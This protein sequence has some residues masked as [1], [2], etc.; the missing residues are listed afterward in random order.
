M[1]GKLTARQ[2]LEGTTE[3]L[4]HREAAF[5]ELMMLHLANVNPAFG[6]FRELFD[7]RGLTETTRV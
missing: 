3:G 1:R 4:P 7:D 6:P 2:W 5:E